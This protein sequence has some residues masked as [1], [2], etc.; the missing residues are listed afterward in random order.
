MELNAVNNVENT[1]TTAHLAS[2]R[3]DEVAGMFGRIARRYDLANTLL[4]AGRDAG[5]RRMASRALVGALVERGGHDLRILDF[6]A[7]TGAQS[8]SLVEEGFRRGAGVRVAASDLALPMLETLARRKAEG[9]GPWGRLGG[10]VDPVL[11]DAARPPLRP[12]TAD[13]AVV[14]FGIRNVDDYRGCLRRVAGVLRPGGWLAVLEFSMPQRQPL[15]G[16][17]RFYFKRVLPLL[18]RLLFDAGGA[19]AYLPDSVDRFPCGAAFEAEL[20]GAGYDS[21]TSQALFGGVVTLYLARS[22]IEGGR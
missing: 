10:A 17:Y 3:R 19:Y 1:G 5:W 16:L 8:L 22:A 20:R 13:G 6:C 9:R 4:S 7:G 15:R 18:G 2:G 11:A 21:V 14:S 12:G